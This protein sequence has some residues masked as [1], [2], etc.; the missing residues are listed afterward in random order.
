[1]ENLFSPEFIGQ[2][3]VFI[4][5]LL[6]AF[7]AH[8]AGHAWMSHRYGDDTAYMLGR[9]TLNP[10]KHIE[11]FGSIILP[12]MGFITS[13]MGGFGLIGWA[14]PC[15]VNPS[16]WTN[17][18]TA[19][20]MVS[21]AGV[22]ANLALAIIFYVVAKALMIGGVIDFTD[23]LIDKTNPLA[24]LLRYGIFMNAS[25]IVLNL[26]PIPPLDGSKILRSILPSSFDPMLDFLDRFGMFLL[27]GLLFTGVLGKIFFPVQMLVVY[28][29]SL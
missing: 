25:L 20:F 6:L 3:L 26:L 16:K 27:L 29:L 11:P 17:Y 5:V 24:T 22:L 13:A 8:E 10:A 28:L 9:V 18:R 12:V 14:K 1:M 4:A 23:I 19:N 2:L 15:P 21:I 7:S